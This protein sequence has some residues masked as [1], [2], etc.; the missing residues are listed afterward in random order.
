M[1]RFFYT[2]R[3]HMVLLL[4]GLVLPIVA[5]VFYVAYVDG[6]TAKR[7]AEKDVVRQARAVALQEER[8]ID[9]A[10]QL[11]TTLAQLPEVN[12]SDPPAASRL[13]AHL[14]KQNPSYVN[15]GVLSA[16]GELR[17]GALPWSRPIS[18]S[19]NTFFQKAVRSRGFVIGEYE[20]D[21]VAGSPSLH[22]GYPVSDPEGRLQ[23]VL[24]ATVGPQWI[25][26]IVQ[27]ENLQTGSSLLL[28]DNQGAILE[29]YPESDRE[30]P[31]ASEDPIVRIVLA[32]REGIAEVAGAGGIPRV[33]AFTALGEDASPS[34]YFAIGFSCK[35]ISAPARNA[36][37]RNLTSLGIIALLAVLFAWIVSERLI[38]RRVK[39]LAETARRFG[40]GQLEQRS[41]ITGKD[42]IGLL[43][44]VFNEMG[45]RIGQMLTTERH[46]KEDVESL[47][48]QMKTLLGM[49]PEGVVLL[50][51]KGAIL[52]SNTAAQAILDGGSPGIPP[53]FTGGFNVVAHVQR[54][55]QAVQEFETAHHG[56]VFEH[57]ISRTSPSG[58]VVW[59]F[60]DLT[61]K[62]RLLAQTVHRSKM[63]DLG[64]LAA[65]IA[66]EIGNPLS[67]MSAILQVLEHKKIPAEILARLKPFEVHIARIDKIVHQIT[68]FA[69][70]S[71]ETPTRIP[72]RILLQKANEIFHLHDRGRNTQVRLPPSS[73]SYEID[74]VED[75]MIQVLLNLLLNA[76]DAMQES[77]SIHMN[78]S[79]TEQEVRIAVADSGQGI[80]EEARRNLFTAFFTTKTAGRGVGLG[81]F[82]SESIVRAHGGRIEVESEPGKGSTFT[83]CLPR[84]ERIS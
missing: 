19:R 4:L 79:Q 78:V 72:T 80:S 60:R 76:A 63:A 17:A 8:L 83:V 74:V 70:P 1:H 71:K 6:R 33:Y 22:F 35:A 48:R 44:R 84:P 16:D 40:S 61:E 18:F 42:E 24:F 53:D 65:G 69:R 31:S 5:L 58:P 50:D 54:L 21:A 36:L 46:A 68:D 27:R 77:G 38:L 14:L 37:V 9:G 47:N 64:L 81:L 32:Q 26:D 12:L 75:Q 25:N 56:R 23:H 39:A 57:A 3:F 41:G 11:L 55:E 67:S 13:L 20:R 7:R 30:D 51:D 43:A 2:L 82:V 34:A 15:L 45:E 28:L 29:R 10:R 49:L 73:Q 66:H 62:R 59:V 52:L